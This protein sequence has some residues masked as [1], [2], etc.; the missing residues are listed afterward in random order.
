MVVS[1][2]LIRLIGLAVTVVGTMLAVDGPGSVAGLFRW[3]FAYA[4]VIV[5]GVAVVAL[6]RNVAPRGSLVGPVALGVVGLTVVMLRQRWWP[7]IGGWSAAGVGMALVGGL[8]VM[9]R[10]SPPVRPGPVRRVVGAV[11]NREI[12]YGAGHDAPERLSV[13]AIGCRIKVN[14]VSAGLPRHGLVEI[15]IVCLVGHVEIAVPLSWPVV[16]GRVNNTHGVRLSG[17]LD[18]TETFDDPREGDQA[19]ELGELAAR[20]KKATRTRKAGVPVV[21]HIVGYGGGVTVVD[22]PG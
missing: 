2:R 12:V 6:V 17:S 10:G 19:E 4:G 16:A 20:R 15:N 18:S 13:V 9:Q 8:I 14:L 21:V 1:G 22:R 3:V 7:G 5:V 11:F